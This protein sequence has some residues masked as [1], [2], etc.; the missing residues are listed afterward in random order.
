MWNAYHTIPIFIILFSYLL[1]LMCCLLQPFTFSSTYRS[2]YFLVIDQRKQA[3]LQWLQ[4]PSQINGGN[5]NNVRREASKHFKI[6]KRE[7]L[8]DKINE[9]ATHSKNK[10]VR[11]WYRGINEFRKG[12]QHRTNLVK[13]ENGDMPADSC[14]ILNTWKNYCFQL[15]NVQIA[16]EM[17]QA[18]V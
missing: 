16:A 17:I 8:K 10:N 1:G 3:R 12:Y 9:L 4:V 13:D 15:L 6:K 7:Y 2:I 11:D 18:G 5:L 14:N